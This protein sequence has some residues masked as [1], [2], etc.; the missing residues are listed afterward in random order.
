M[1]RASG[2]TG[3]GVEPTTKRVK[4]AV[5]LSSFRRRFSVEARSSERR[6]SETNPPQKPYNPLAGSFYMQERR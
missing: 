2:A 4:L 1:G 3:P 6:L 5:D